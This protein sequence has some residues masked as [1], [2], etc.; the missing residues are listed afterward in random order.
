MKIH[1]ITYALGGEPIEVTIVTGADESTSIEL[2]EG[3]APIAWLDGDN[4]VTVESRCDNTRTV[5]I[6]TQCTVRLYTTTFLADLYS[7]DIH[8]AAVTISYGGN[9]IFRGWV[10]ARA[11]S[12]DYTGE[13]DVVELQCVDSLTLLSAMKFRG[14]DSESK[15]DE[16][17]AAAGDSTFLALLDEALTAAT[18]S[19]ADYS[20]YYDGSRLLAED[21]STNILSALHISDYLYIGDEEDAVSTYDQVVEDIL[22]YLNLH[23]MQYG[24]CFYLFHW[25]T[26]RAGTQSWTQ[27][28]GGGSATP[29]TT[30][31]VVPVTTDTAYGTSA[32][33]DL[34]EIY[35]QVFLTISPTQEDDVLESPFESSALSTVGTAFKYATEYAADGE[36]VRAARAFHTLIN[37]GWTAKSVYENNVSNYEEQMAWKDFWFK[38]RRHD[39]WTFGRNGVDW[40]SGDYT[41]GADLVDKL[42]SYIDGGARVYKYPSALMLSIGAVDHKPGQGDSNKQGRISYTDKLVIYTN[43]SSDEGGS[44]MGTWSAAADI[45]AAA[46]LA[47]YTGG[48]TYSRYSTDGAHEYLVITG[49]IKMLPVLFAANDYS[50]NGDSSNLHL[51]SAR[52][53]RENDLPSSWALKGKCFPS[54]N[55]GDGRYL[56]MDW[57]SDGTNSVDEYPTTSQ[58]FWTHWVPDTDDGPELFEYTG[59]EVEDTDTGVDAIDRIPVLACMMIIGEKCLVEELSAAG[60]VNEYTLKWVDYKERSACASDA[61]YYAQSFTLGIDPTVGDDLIGKEYS[62]GTNFDF[63]SGI[64][65]DDGFAIPLFDESGEIALGGKIDFRIIGPT[66]RTWLHTISDT[67][68]DNVV[69]SDSIPAESTYGRCSNLMAYV[70]SIIVSDFEVK[71]VTDVVE[72]DDTSD[73]VYMSDVSHDYYNRLEETT[74]NIHSGF[75]ADE[76]AAFGLADGVIPS[77]V[78]T[79]DGTPVMYIYDNSG[80]GNGAGKPEQLWVSEVYDEWHAPRVEFTRTMRLSAWSS[81]MMHISDATLSREFFV[82]S[83]K[84]DLYDATA[85]IKG[86][87]K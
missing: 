39:S 16:V 32:Q 85:K 67:E 83:F 22:G 70:D 49:S 62:I 65:A 29:Y 87:E 1:G 78:R 45:Y 58:P 71:A 18:G 69:V 47:T 74:W 48:N 64:N 50:G 25:G 19:L 35:N 38:I 36:G 31:D 41:H 14:V 2:G 9:V 10:S 12:Q 4:P 3:E 72:T 77:T 57:Y 46:P 76:C 84:L 15:Y 6:P 17:R 20:V 75:T 54:R 53:Q 56:T 63:T 43:G 30:G 68:I 81:P 13:A 66:W 5:I 40:A 51:M 27:V 59:A 11:Y 86:K 24:D 82:E 73:I 79:V 26:V 33:I 60:D 44:V 37:A 55:N 34:D 61:E 42:V 52:W 28:L 7:A 8:T 80:L 23:V 21:N